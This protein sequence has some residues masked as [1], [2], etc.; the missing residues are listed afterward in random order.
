M[1]RFALFAFASLALAACTPTSTGV[2]PSPTPSESPS[3]VASATSSVVTDQAMYAAEVLYNVPAQ[4]YVAADGAKLISPELKAKL[5]PMLVQAYSILQGARTAYRLKN[6]LAFA[7]A[8]S[9]LAKLSADIM[10]LIP[11]KKGT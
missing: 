11:I 5:K 2:E 6:A 8:N 10:A 1:K 9:E 3:P 7:S 4:A